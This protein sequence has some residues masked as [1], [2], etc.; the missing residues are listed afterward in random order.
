MRKY[1]SYPV[2]KVINIKKLIAIDYLYITPDFYFET[3]T[4]NF[5]EFAYVDGGTIVC[6]ADG[7][8][9]ELKQ[10]DFY[11]IDPFVPHH[12]EYSHKENAH[13]FVVCFDSSSDFFELVR[14]KTQLS[15]DDKKLMS[16]IF[17]ESK[18]TFKFPR[19]GKLELLD[20]PA[21]GSQQL[22]EN[23]IEALL[24]NIIRA[25]LSDRP[26]IKFVM[27][28]TDFNNKLV[29]DIISI[30]KDNL[31]GKVTLEQ[32]QSLLFYSTTYLNNNF[33]KIT[34]DSIMH[35][36]RSLKIEEAKKLIKNGESIASI[37]ERL[38][39]ESPNYFSKVFRSITGL[40]P[41]KYKKTI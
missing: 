27:N 7:I 37:S 35:Y 32:I 5:Y 13:L 22:I 33:K 38:Y 26:E 39:F 10:G 31:D 21:F 17:S 14:E 4:H 34:G 1:Y 23:N 18:R 9:T 19:K 20:A 24:I 2:K 3:E 11:L 25:K 40:T 16:A 8:R 6:E 30:L 28:S 12:Y 15:E 29:N 36:Y 41:S